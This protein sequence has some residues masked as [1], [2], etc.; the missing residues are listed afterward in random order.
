MATHRQPP[1]D[2]GGHERSALSGVDALALVERLPAVTYIADAGIGGRWHYISP[3]VHA[4]L[5]FTPEEWL[6]DPELWARLLHADD[7]ARVFA[8]EADVLSEGGETPP[9]DYRLTHRDGRTV[10]VRDD[11]ALMADEQRPRA[12]ARRAVGHHRAQADGGRAAAPRGAA[13]RGRANR[14]AGARRRET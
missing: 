13:G 1:R 12:V 14:R 4:L 11:A 6:A 7:R 8:R 5:G 9:E 2:E 10:W 3:Q